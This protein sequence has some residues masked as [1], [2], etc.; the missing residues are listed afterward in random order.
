MAESMGNHAE[1]VNV[2]DVFLQGVTG[3]GTVRKREVGVGA[4]KDESDLDAM[5]PG[6]EVAGTGGGVNG[7]R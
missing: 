7:R 2:M 6:T 1:L 4:D 3:E 5:S